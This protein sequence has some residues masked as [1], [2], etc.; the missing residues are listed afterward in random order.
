M[1]NGLM[2]GESEGEEDATQKPVSQDGMVGGNPDIDPSL[3]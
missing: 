2:V 1:L 3:T